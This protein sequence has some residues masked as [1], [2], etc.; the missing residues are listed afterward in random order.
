MS[1]LSSLCVV[2]GDIWTLFQGENQR[3]NVQHLN[4][5]Q[6]PSHNTGRTNERG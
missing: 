1:G 5:V 2:V 4:G 3:G 6:T